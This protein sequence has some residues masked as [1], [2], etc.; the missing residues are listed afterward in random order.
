MAVII[1]DDNYKSVIIVIS[2]SMLLVINYIT[3]IYYQNDQKSMF[4]G[5]INVCCDHMAYN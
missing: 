1:F 5:V 3:K 4:Y 2:S